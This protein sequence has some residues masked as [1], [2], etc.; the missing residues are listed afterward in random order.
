LYIAATDKGGKTDQAYFFEHF[1]HVLLRLYILLI[2][3]IITT[4]GTVKKVIKKLD[5]LR[6]YSHFHL[7]TE[8]G[9]IYLFTG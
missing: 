2:A 8:K 5:N 3:V 9:V 1:S 6:I 4:R 7:Y